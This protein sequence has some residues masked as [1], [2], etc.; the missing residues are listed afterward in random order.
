[1]EYNVYLKNRN[2]TT[3]SYKRKGYSPLFIQD[4]D[5]STHRSIQYKL[6]KTKFTPGISCDIESVTYEET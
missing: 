6:V 3:K 2:G 5:A 4:I 1:M